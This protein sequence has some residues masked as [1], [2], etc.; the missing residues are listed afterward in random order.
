MRKLTADEVDT[1]M[2]RLLKA[3]SLLKLGMIA[4]REAANR[5]SEGRGATAIVADF[6]YV[7][8]A[9]EDQLDQPLEILGDLQAGNVMYCAG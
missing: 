3:H 2:D 7:L 5:P 8:W 4:A 6:Q 9:I 1:A